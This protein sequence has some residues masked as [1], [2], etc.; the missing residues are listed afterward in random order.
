[1]S[2]YTCNPAIRVLQ[3]Q[4]GLIINCIY[5][6]LM[7]KPRKGH[8]CPAKTQISL[9]ICPVWSEASLSAW[10]KLGSLAAHW[11]HGEDWSDWADAQADLSLRWTYMPFCWFC[12]EAAHFMTAVWLHPR[13]ILLWHLMLGGWKINVFTLN[14]RYDFLFTAF[15]WLKA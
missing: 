10:R 15:A 5:S 6:H 14:M 8:V 3:G 12:H 4:P 7:T 13:L 1:M 9:G 11:V 2:C